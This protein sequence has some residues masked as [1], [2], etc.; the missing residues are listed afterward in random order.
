MDYEM[1]ISEDNQYIRIR[2]MSD[3]TID[4]VERFSR[5]ASEL[6]EQANI[7]RI[8]SDER[9]VKSL[10]NVAQTHAFAHKSWRG[11]GPRPGWRIAVLKAPDGTEYDCVETVMVNAGFEFR[12]FDEEDEAVAWLV[13]PSPASNLPK[14]P[15]VGREHPARS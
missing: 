2:V 3:I 9:G 7:H 13:E 10:T 1:T 12:I 11:P 15:R 6:S 4:L 14:A 5:D 8:L